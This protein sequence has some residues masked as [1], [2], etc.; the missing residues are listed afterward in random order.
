MKQVSSTIDPIPVGEAGD[1]TTAVD[2]WTG[3]SE[4]VIRR[5]FDVLCIER[6]MPKQVI[7]GPNWTKARC[8]ACAEGKAPE[9][10]PLGPSRQTPIKPTPK[11]KSPNAWRGVGSM[12]ADFKLK[13]AGD[14]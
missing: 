10:P 3:I 11:L 12:A 6:G 13:Q 4:D 5:F 8:A 14:R 2:P 1:E 7:T 9:L